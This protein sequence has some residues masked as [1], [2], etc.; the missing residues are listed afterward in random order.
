MRAHKYWIKTHTLTHFA[1][2]FLV[3]LFLSRH[4][5]NN[6]QVWHQLHSLKNNSKMNISNSYATPL[7]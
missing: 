1:L 3:S 7:N 4:L 2:L 5:Q 6:F